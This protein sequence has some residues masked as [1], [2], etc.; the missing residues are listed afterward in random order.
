MRKQ[1]ITLT[2]ILV[3]ANAVA[4]ILLFY[5]YFPWST[6][7]DYEK[8][9]QEVR[10]DLLDLNIRMASN[11]YRFSKAIVDRAKFDLNQDIKQKRPSELDLPK[12]I[13]KELAEERYKVYM[14]NED[15]PI[16]ILKLNAENYLVLGPYYAAYDAV[17]TRDGIAYLILLA[18]FNGLCVWGAFVYL[19]SRLEPANQ[20]IK[21]VS[22]SIYLDKKSSAIANVTENIPELVDKIHQLQK[23]HQHNIR[24]Q[25]DLMHAVA[26]EFRGPMARIT[27]AIDL[28]T[29]DKEAKQQEQLKTDIEDSLEELDSLVKEV[30]DYSRLKDGQQALNLDHFDMQ[31]IIELAVNKVSP[32]YPKK[33]FDTVF[34]PA[35]GINCV[36]DQK[37]IERALLNL[38][39]N[40]AK[41]SFSKILISAKKDGDS[42]IVTVED[43]G[44]G[45][46]P[47]KRERIFE[48]FTRLD[49]SRSR[50]SGGAGLGLAIVW[51]IANRHEGSI[52]VRDSDSLGG[53]EFTLKLPLAIED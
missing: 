34:D 23:E 45:V 36:Q 53:A 51:G 18:I 35:T 16:G 9:Q 14:E 2:A 42:V 39:R 49:H 28:L 17:N 21:R 12:E 31:D 32:F 15:G 48:P 7:I 29:S 5:V 47:G 46:P 6:D 11:E 41:F 50:D 27:F 38:I 4:G 24:S 40:A 26:H 52:E 44:N 25:Q 30:L 22:A 3:L 33:T 10:S 43:D 13:E 1:L 8:A 20:A 19:R 37:L